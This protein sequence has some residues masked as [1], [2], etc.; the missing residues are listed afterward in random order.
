MSAV[1]YD[2]MKGAA[3]DVIDSTTFTEILTA[4]VDSVDPIRLVLEGNGLVITADMVVRPEI[5]SEPNATIQSGSKVY[6]LA[7]STRDLFFI[8]STDPDQH[9]SNLVNND[10]LGTVVDD[11]I[12]DALVDINDLINQI[13]TTANGKNKV[14][15]ETYPP[16]TNEGFIAGDQWWVYSDEDNSLVIGF[17]LFSGSIWQQQ[18]MENAILATLDAAKIT[19]GYLAAARLAAGTITAEN[20]ILADL[21]V[22]TAKIADLAVTGAKIQDATITNAKIANATITSAK[23]VSIEADKI[24]VGTLT[25]FTVTGGT[26][27]TDTSGER[28]VITSSGFTS[29]LTL[30]SALFL[31]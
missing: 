5:Y 20:G 17:Y 6:V 24:N 8:L 14:R 18:V 12:E 19:T 3:N 30:L 29:S 25:G 1:L 28:I 11:K 2:L 9:Q 23:I 4:T 31:Y 7:S 10:S 27:Q 15:R 13:G 22:T 21:A 26:L 16:D